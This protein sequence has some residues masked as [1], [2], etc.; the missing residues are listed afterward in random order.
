VDGAAA[1]GSIHRC[2]RAATA[3]AVAG[4]SAVVV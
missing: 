4:P 3:S 1:G 2:T